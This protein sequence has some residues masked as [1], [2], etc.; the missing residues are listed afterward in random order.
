M[1]I[2]TICDCSKAE[3][4]KFYRERVI[5]RVPERIRGPL[6]F[7]V[8]YDA[9]GGKLAHWH[10]YITD[11]GS[12]LIVSLSTHHLTFIRFLVNSNGTLDSECFHNHIAY[13]PSNG[14]K[15]LVKQSSHFLQAH[16]LLNLHIIHSS[17]AATGGPPGHDAE[18]VHDRWSQRR[19]RKRQH[20]R[21]DA[22][23]RP[24]SCRFQ[25]LLPLHFPFSPV[26]ATAG[27]G[28]SSSF[29]GSTSMG[30]E[31]TTRVLGYAVVESDVSTVE[32]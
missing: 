27:I 24:R 9:F 2:I 20:D 7:E 23:P 22:S 29:A 12:F 6:N 10:D 11:Y 15:S 3:T 32:D 8:L 19:Q 18:M 25:D 17:Q 26:P 4:R 21:R 5:P 1:Q 31:W 28:D 16:S 13:S 14:I 30:F